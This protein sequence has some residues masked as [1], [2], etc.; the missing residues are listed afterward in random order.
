MTLL[1][2]PGPGR[3][4]GLRPVD[5]TTRREQILEVLRAAVSDGTLAP[6]VHLAEVEL[7]EQLGVSRGTLREALRHL[8]QDGLLVPDNR[9]RLSVRVVSA[10]EVADI[11]AVRAALEALAAEQVCSRQDRS[12]AVAVLEDRLAAMAQPAADM[13]ERV[14]RD[15]A[16]HEALCTLSGNDVLHAS[17]RNVSGLAR[18]AV[19]AAG[20]SAALAN[21]AAAR[22]APLVALVRDGDGEGAQRFLRQHMAEAAQNLLTQMGDGSAPS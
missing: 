15:L 14:T 12:G 7:S 13:G 22:H 16:F 5:R 2:A 11:F 4:S 8:Q 1:D 19:T 20:P 18:A 17:W 9:G 3:P 10:H 21:T 6:G